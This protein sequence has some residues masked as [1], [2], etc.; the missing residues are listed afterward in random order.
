MKNSLNS[1]LLYTK[2][3]RII[4]WRINSN[5]LAMILIIIIKGKFGLILR[6]FH[7][8]L[9]SRCSH[10]HLLLISKPAALC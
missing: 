4:I 6:H 3:S 2:L 10:L 1:F 7:A 5:I 9:V 8:R